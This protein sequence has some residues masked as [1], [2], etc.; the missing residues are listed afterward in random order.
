MKKNAMFK[1]GVEFFIVHFCEQNRD[2]YTNLM[3][4]SHPREGDKDGYQIA[5]EAF[6]KKTGW[7]LAS[8]RDALFN[9]GI[10][11]EFAINVYRY[12]E[13]NYFGIDL[14]SHR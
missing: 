2:I 14:I 13:M 8:E 12:L 1:E 11:P 4:R 3:A 9:D 5:V 10:I 6:Y 7:L